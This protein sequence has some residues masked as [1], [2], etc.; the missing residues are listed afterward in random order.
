M[1]ACFVPFPESADSEWA[2]VSSSA[3]SV[4]AA[5]AG[6]AEPLLMASVEVRYRIAIRVFGV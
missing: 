4:R 6:V 2:L 3:F 5:P 1:R